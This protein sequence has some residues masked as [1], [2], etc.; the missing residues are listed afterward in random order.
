[1]TVV[2]ARVV[3]ELRGVSCL[4]L[5]AVPPAKKSLTCSRTF[6]V[7]VEA[8]P[9]LREAVATD[10]ARAAERL[11]RYGLAAG[12]VTV[13]ITTNRFAKDEPHYS[14]SATVEM[15]FPSEATQELQA[16]AFTILERLYRGG[17]KYKKVGVM[18]S[19]LVP[20]SPITARMYDEAAWQRA[21]RV[22]RAVDEINRKVGRD[23]VRF[24]VS[25]IRRAWQTKFE[26]RSPRYT[27]AWSD[28]LAV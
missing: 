20:A 16:R 28:V 12:T 27:T 22:I 13:W 24:A 1:M 6:G 7:H 17:K 21:R 4:P 3:K 5:E 14:N 9:Q 25:G 2:G 23:T 18:L 15:A 10:S 11:R 8:L 19:R 26:R